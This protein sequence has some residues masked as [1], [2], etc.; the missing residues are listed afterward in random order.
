MKVIHR[1]RLNVRKEEAMGKRIN[2]SISGVALLTFLALFV[3]ATA[4]S[5]TLEVLNPRGEIKPPPTLAP[6]PRIADLAGKKI[7]IYWNGKMGGNNFWD[8]IEQLLKEKYP[9][10]TTVRYSGPFIPGDS[11]ATKMV[12]ECDTFIYG[13]GD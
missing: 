12:K 1:M 10:A 8:A 2:L 5:V 9:T 7:G 4:A 6:V 13:V 11:L 3:P